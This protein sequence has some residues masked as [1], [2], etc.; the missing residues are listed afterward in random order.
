MAAAAGGDARALAA[1]L[2][3]EITGVGLRAFG[4][5]ALNAAISGPERLAQVYDDAA[6]GWRGEPVV[7][8][9]VRPARSAPEAVDPA[10]WDAFWQLAETPVEGQDPATFTGR[11]AWMAG[12]LSPGLPARVAACAL[13][14]PGVRDAA[15]RGDT[16]PFRLERLAAAPPGSLG[17]A[18]HA[19]IEAQGGALELLDREALGLASLPPPL[20]YANTRVLQ[21][22]E[23]WRIAAGY[24]P[25]ELH[26]LALT[27]FQ[28]GQFGHHYSSL[29]LSV[30]L[31]VVALERSD[32]AP[33]ILDTIFAG[34][35]H[36]RQSPPLLGVDWEPLWDRPLEAVRAQL[37]LHPFASRWPADA[38]VR[39]FSK[40]A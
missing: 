8:P 7:A 33:M 19:A 20:D 2:K 22:H 24:Q 23:L 1:G 37:G 4:A 32:D 30:A 12:L 36:G 11:V 40:A 26:R 9:M 21:C 16:T 5:L 6:T 3:R 31:S 14:F 25:T 28:M 34:W 10:F 35:A 13:A 15:A 27:A 29:V 38:F 17:Q 18:F 39:R